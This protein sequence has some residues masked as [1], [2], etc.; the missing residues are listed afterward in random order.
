MRSSPGVSTSCFCTKHSAKSH[1]LPSH[2]NPYNMYY[3][4][5]QYSV[6][7]CQRV[8]PGLRGIADFFF[9]SQ[10]LSD[11]FFHDPRDVTK[12]IYH[13]LILFLI[14]TP[15]RHRRRSIILLLYLYSTHKHNICVNN[16]PRNRGCDTALK[17]YALFIPVVFTRVFMS[18]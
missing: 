10:N 16:L 13:H 9:S 7:D 1:S 6:V 5:T 3:N 2:Q 15:P 18:V 11:C 12:F 8:A 14:D 17:S 4:E